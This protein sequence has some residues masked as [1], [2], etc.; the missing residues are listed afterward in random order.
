MKGVH[1]LAQALPEVMQQN[2]EMYA[3]FVGNAGVA[4]DGG[5]MHE[6]VC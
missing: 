3:V 4:P 1:Y 6:F 2:P 5:T